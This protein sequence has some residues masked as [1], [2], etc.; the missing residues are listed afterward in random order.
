MTLSQK[1]EKY[2]L[3]RQAEADLSALWDRERAGVTV[4]R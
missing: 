1:I 3:R 4:E 2:K